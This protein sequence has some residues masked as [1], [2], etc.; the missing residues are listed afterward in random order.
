MYLKEEL[1][2]YQ[3]NEKMAVVLRKIVLFCAL[4]LCLFIAFI[5][6]TQ[7]LD[8]LDEELLLGTDAYRFMRQSQLIIEQGRLPEREM[9]RWTPIGRDMTTQLSFSSYVI[10]YLYKFIRTFKHT[11]SLHSVALYYPVLCYLLAL[12]IL[13]L[14]AEKLFNANTALLSVAIASVHSSSLL[15]SMA[16]FCDRD[17]LCLTLS[18]CSFYLYVRRLEAKSLRSSL[19]WS[20]SSGLIMMVLGLTWEGVGIF[21]SVIILVNLVKLVAGSY[22]VLDLWSYVAWFTPVLIGLLIFTRT[23]R[24]PSYYGAPFILPALLVPLVVLFIALVYIIIR[25]GLKQSKWYITLAIL[26]CMLGMLL[27]ISAS[28]YTLT[29]VKNNILS[30]LG[31]NRLMRSISELQEYSLE[32]WL[33]TYRFTFFLFSIGALF[34]LYKI[35]QCLGINPW[36][37]MTSF[38]IFLISVFYAKI[39]P[40]ISMIPF[41]S[42]SPSFFFGSAVLFIAVVLGLYIYSR[43]RNPCLNRKL[44]EKYCMLLAWFTIMLICTKGARRYE[45]FFVPVM[46]VLASYVLILV[47]KW[48]TTPTHSQDTVFCIL[49]VA[50]CWEF[51][52][53]YPRIS[54]LVACIVVTLVITIIAFRQLMMKAKKRGVRCAG[55]ILVTLF[56]IGLT[57]LFPPIGGYAMVGYVQA[58]KMT[59]VINKPSLDAYKWMKEEVHGNAVVAAWWDYG[60]EIN[61][62]AGKATIIGEDTYIPYWIHLMARHVFCG[63]SEREALEF[64]KTHK[65][66]YL[67]IKENELWHMP[68]ISAIGSDENFDKYL[69]FVILTSKQEFITEKRKLITLLPLSQPKVGIELEKKKYLPQKWAIKKV[70]LELPSRD[71]FADINATI[72]AYVENREIRLPVKHLYLAGKKV[73][74]EGKTFPGG[75]YLLNR[76]IFY[77][78]GQKEEWRAIYLPEESLKNL[79]VRLFL[80]GDRS[81]YF[82]LVYPHQEQMSLLMKRHG[83]I[84]VMIW[85]IIY[86]KYI[87][88]NPKYLEKEFSNPQLSEAWIKGDLEP[89]D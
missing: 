69:E 22:T 27:F 7:N 86:P 48:I 44:D 18:L 66:Q 78:N 70:F 33:R 36:L 28:S 50:I 61:V 3:N 67:L 10:A 6:R 37:A 46:A 5:L 80:L 16:G 65:A 53:F 54:V 2:A 25:R 20:G 73:T 40:H 21:V 87:G 52:I 31:L 4:T 24:Y 38:V 17:A 19:V 42:L 58:K 23:Y 34:L 56:I 51:Y 76:T 71:R 85:K 60:S 75:L 89:P 9:M 32:R 13:F 72:V 14:L 59:P 74:K 26:V 57:S 39:P 47:C 68:T 30:P 15:R 81:S 88:T 8:S 63:Q 64:L 12:I 84:P 62:L 29:S 83:I 41:S 82:H 79:T 45:F 55:W 35:S 1:E 11:V 43:K 49:L 77:K